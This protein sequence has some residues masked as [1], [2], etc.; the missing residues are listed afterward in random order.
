LRFKKEKNKHFSL[1]CFILKALPI[2]KQREV[3][4]MTTP[5]KVEF[6]T[7]SGTLLHT[8]HILAENMKELERRI[9]WFADTFTPFNQIEDIRWKASTEIATGV[10]TKERT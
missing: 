6:V 10:I 5:Y 3:F 9:N 1:F 2:P 4:I 7:K 8:H